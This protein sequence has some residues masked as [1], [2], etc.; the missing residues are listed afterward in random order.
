MAETVTQITSF[1]QHNP[2]MQM[3]LINYHWQNKELFHMLLSMILCL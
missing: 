1:Y 2:A 3:E